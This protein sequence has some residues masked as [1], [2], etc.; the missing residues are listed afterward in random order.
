MTAA[1]QL[2]S[3]GRVRLRAGLAA[4]DPGGEVVAAWQGKELLR[5]VYAADGPADARRALARFYHWCDGVGVAELSRLAR[6]VRAW[7]AEILAWHA[8][9]G[10][11][12]GPTE[13]VNLLIKSAWN[14]R[15]ESASLVGHPRRTAGGATTRKEP[16]AMA[17]I[18]H[19]GP[20]HLGLDVHRNTISVATLLPDQVSAAV[21][22]IPS[23]EAAVLAF[24]GRFAEPGP[25]TGLL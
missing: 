1:E 23:D 13:A 5:G 16:A 22:Q 20:I 15:L 19:A 8:T 10:C 3:R 9:G 14:G 18:P 2:A 11:S 4:G 24:L 12:N 6:T 25:P 17:R 21:E 7:E